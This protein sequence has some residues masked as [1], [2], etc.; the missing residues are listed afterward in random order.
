MVTRWL[1][2]TQPYI[3][4]TNRRKGRRSAHWDC[5]KKKKKNLPGSSH[6]LT[7]K[8][9]FCLYLL[10]QNRVTWL[11]LAAREAGRCIFTFS[12]LCSKGRQ[13]KSESV[14]DF[15]EAKPLRCLDYLL[16]SLTSSCWI[17]CHKTAFC[18]SSDP[19]IRLFQWSPSWMF[20]NWTSAIRQKYNTSHRCSFKCSSSHVLREL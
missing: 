10:G 14:N 11:P 18:W 6:S 17:F 16:E 15:W 9:D 13:G 12:S 5:L 4:S 8:N 7:T 1:P 19:L 2:D 20:W 3:C